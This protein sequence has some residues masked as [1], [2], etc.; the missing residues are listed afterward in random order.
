MQ[1]NSLAGLSMIQAITIGSSIM[2]KSNGQR[3]MNKL[4]ALFYFFWWVGGGLYRQVDSLFNMNWRK[5][6][7]LLSTLI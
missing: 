1:V 5:T 7:T 4:M 3:T 2:G 6:L